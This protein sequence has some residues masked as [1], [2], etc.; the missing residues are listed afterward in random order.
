MTC[1][2][3]KVNLRA[4][5]IYRLDNVAA[6]RLSKQDIE[7]FIEMFP[8]ASLKSKKS[9][10]M[11]FFLPLSEPTPQTIDTTKTVEHSKEDSRIT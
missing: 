11:L 7:T 8:N 3:Y 2:K 4:Q 9:K 1:L 5:H 6:D 10:K